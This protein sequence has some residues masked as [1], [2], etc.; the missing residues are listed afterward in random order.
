MID[1]IKNFFIKNI[2]PVIEEYRHT[3]QDFKQIGDRVLNSIQKQSAY[4]E[5]LSK[6][7]Q[8]IF[9]SVQL[10]S[11]ATQVMERETKEIKEL[12]D[13]SIS[14]LD[15]LI[16]IIE[17][18]TD[19]VHHLTEILNNIKEHS[20]RLKEAIGEIDKISEMTI[21]AARNA[22]IKAY[23]AGDWG[24]GFEVIARQ[25]VNLVG[26]TET[27]TLEIPKITERVEVD[28]V[29]MATLVEDMQKFLEKFEMVSEYLNDSF[30]QILTIMP[31]L[32]RD[33]TE[34][35][36]LIAEQEKAKEILL[37]SNWELNNWL[38]DTF[39]FSEKAASATIFL[40]GLSNE[41]MTKAEQIKTWGDESKHNFYYFLIRFFNILVSTME[42][43]QRWGQK[44][45]HIEGV[46]D[47]DKF[48]NTLSALKATGQDIK[49]SILRQSTDLKKSETIL[50]S[51]L[52]ALTRE[53]SEEIGIMRALDEAEILLSRLKDLPDRVLFF[54]HEL[55]AI[56]ERSR[57]LS[58]YAA[59][60]SARSGTYTQSLSV[61]ADE[62]KILAGQAKKSVGNIARWRE[63]LVTDFVS[64]LKIIEEAKRIAQDERLHLNESSKI[65]EETLAKTKNLC[66]LIDE[67]NTSIDRQLTNF[68]LLEGQ[69][70]N[71]IATHQ[72]IV[73][74]FE[75]YIRAGILLPKAL[76]KVMN[77][78]DEYFIMLANL[79]KEKEP[80]V[81]IIVRESADP[82]ILDPSLKTE[83]VSDRILQHLHIGLF[84]FDADGN[85]VPGA[86]SDYHISEDGKVWTFYLRKDIKF[87][88][89][90]P[91]TAA[92]VFF[93]IERIRK[94]P[95]A[96]FVEFIE[97]TK[98]IDDHTI[99]FK[100]RFP[101]L[102]FVA[103]LACG[104][105]LIIPRH[106]YDPNHPIGAGP[107]RFVHWDKNNE[108]TLRA[109]D[110]F[111][112]GRPAIDELIFRVIPDEN[113]ALDRFKQGEVSFMEIS[114]IQIDEK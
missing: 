113:E 30:K 105:C 43:H 92:D 84:N 28:V 33:T 9:A 71:V 107:F 57:I 91:L 23:H 104:T 102:P 111:F 25:M 27:A 93:S 38:A 75:H 24:R 68:A 4:L 58:L 16:H 42:G 78:K 98:I 96:G 40:R 112:E 18:L 45:P 3:E 82:L 12:S 99:Q 77:Y 109:N 50:E 39:E 69:L 8:S 72:D 13:H 103:N 14:H 49:Q 2:A 73:I 74:E 59:I 61:V 63:F 47:F 89:G 11:E 51:S 80:E 101:Y 60:E 22:Q 6:G 10:T 106:G 44:V 62:I 86:A 90:Q 34:A 76:E 55:D 5:D 54:E 97:E 1:E 52:S 108:I 37:A 21:V 88:N 26:Q 56:V 87:H 32:D 41:I 70:N 17:Q 53:L 66:L 31:S 7:F 35:A 20:S 100:L 79:I 95:N 83:V 67:T 94:G 81:Q 29:K 48:V 19:K 110:D 114:Q 46:F 85:I 15:G 64:A 65:I 36:R